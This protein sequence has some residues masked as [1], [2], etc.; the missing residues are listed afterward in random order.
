[1]PRRVSEDIPCDAEP[2]SNV[3][4]LAPSE[5]RATK[6][7]QEA[8]DQPKGARYKA[9]P[10]DWEK[11]SQRGSPPERDWIFDHWIGT[12]HVTLLSGGGG[13]G[14]SVLSLQMAVAAAKGLTFI[15]KAPKPRNV[16][17]WMGEDDEDEIWRRSVAICKKFDVPLNQLSGGVFVEPM[18]SVECSLMEKIQGKI[19]RT[20][21]LTELRDQ[22][23][24]TKSE[25]VILDNIGRLFGGNENDRHDVTAF[26]A[27]LNYAAEPMKAAVLLLGHTSKIQGSE[28]SG[29]TAWENSARARLWFS[30]RPPDKTPEKGEDEEPPSDLRYLSKRKVN[31]TSRDLC[32]MKYSDGAYDV[33]EQP[34]SGGLM[35]SLRNASSRRVVQ[36]A[37]SKLTSLNIRPSDAVGAHDNYLPALIVK[38]KF[39]EGH[40]KA[41]LADAMRSLIVDGVLK[42]E[43]VGV[44]ANRNPKFGLVLQ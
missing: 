32:I 4:Y 3:A 7:E 1:M 12:G 40:S 43:Q 19:E 17:V 34:A 29:S 38:Y 11:L 41:E 31:Y 25:L 10:M 2:R 36:T 28:F 27:A 8:F 24:D 6:A 30:D 21:M 42:R 35:S 13:I 39:A 44:Y 20:N 23:T 26:I 37:F 16:L 14:K 18:A 33:V 22:I 15:T 9:N 5:R